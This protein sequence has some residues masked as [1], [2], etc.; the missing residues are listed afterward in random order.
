MADQATP[1]PPPPPAPARPDWGKRLLIGAVA[2]VVIVLS[3]F[4]ASAIIPRWWAQRVAD[5]VNGSLFAGFGL[6]LLY[7]LVFT[8]L[9]LV[10]LWYTFH[11]RRPWK[12]WIGGLI[13]AMIVALPNLMTL[14]IV[15]GTGNAAHGAERTMDVDAPLFRG[16]V[17]VGALL[18]VVVFAFWRYGRGGRTR[19]CTV[20]SR[21]HASRPRR[22]GS[23][24]EHG[25]GAHH[26]RAA[27]GR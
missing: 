18:A 23:P 16:F 12:I 20:S 15:V 6:G 7:G 4:A 1:P 24:G 27:A 8:L 26:P 5:Q 19:S 10:V 11:R 2:V 21:R 9:P 22:A 13:L 25:R 17:A 3:A 14:A